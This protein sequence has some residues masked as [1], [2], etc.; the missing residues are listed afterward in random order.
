MELARDDGWRFRGSQFLIMSCQDRPGV[1]STAIATAVLQV[2]GPMLLVHFLF[3][4]RR[5]TLLLRYPRPCRLD[6][7]HARG[8]IEQVEV[9]QCNLLFAPSAC[10]KKVPGVLRRSVTGPFGDTG[11]LRMDVP[12]DNNSW[13]FVIVALTSPV[14]HD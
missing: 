1:A 2:W 4:V 14:R 12:S 8:A 3:F 10:A 5:G 6:L 9:F 13:C 7:E 11:M